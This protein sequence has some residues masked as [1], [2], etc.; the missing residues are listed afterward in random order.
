MKRRFRDEEIQHKGPA[1]TLAILPGNLSQIHPVITSISWLP[2]YHGN[3]W[4]SVLPPHNQDLL[5]RS[6][7][8][9]AAHPLCTPRCAH[10]AGCVCARV[11]TYI[12]THTPSWLYIKNMSGNIY[13]CCSVFTGHGFQDPSRHQNPRMFKPLRVDG[14]TASPHPHPCI[15]A[16]ASAGAEGR[17]CTCVMR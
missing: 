12:H 16:P 4:L 6:Q 9:A 2:C 8:S 17:R 14:P 1:G 7:F 13:S 10:M 11:Q 3:H 15:C 5:P